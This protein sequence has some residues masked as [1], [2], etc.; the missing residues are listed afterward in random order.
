MDA[1]GFP[2]VALRGAVAHDARK[3]RRRALYCWSTREL[4]TLAVISFHVDS[5]PSVPLVVTNIAIRSDELNALSLFA[6]WMLLD[7]LQDV[8]VAAP[9]RADHEV[10]ALAQTRAQEETLRRLGMRPCTRPAGLT[11][12][13]TWYCYRRT[14][15][16]R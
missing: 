3:P 10:G 14:R 13:G 15:P 16:K 12:P 8:A 4:R 11:K 5:Q 1:R 6:A 7:V 9:K 2:D